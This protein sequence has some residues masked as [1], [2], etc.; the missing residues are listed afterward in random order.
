MLKMDFSLSFPLPRLLVILTIIDG[1][2]CSDIIQVAGDIGSTVSIP[3][4]IQNTSS[5]LVMKQ[6]NC[7]HST[8]VSMD[9]C[10]DCDERMCLRKGLLEIKNLTENDEGKYTLDSENYSQTL[11][12]RLCEL[13]LVVHIHCLSDGRADLFCEA[14]GQSNDSIHW[15]LNGSGMNDI[16]ACQKDGGKRIILEK[17]VHGKLACHRRNSCSSSSI[18]LS[19]NEGNEGSL[20]QPEDLLQ[21]PLFLY[22]LAGCGGGALLLAILASLITCCCLKSK[23]HFISVPAEDEKDEGINLAAISSEGQKSPP[24]GERCEATS[25]LGDST[26]NPGPET[27]E[28]FKPE[29]K[30]DLTTGAK[31][32]S[33]PKI[34]EKAGTETEF[35]EVMVDSAALEAVDVHFPDLTDA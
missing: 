2:T 29:R 7:A 19:C 34:D 3:L 24:N 28:S 25:A 33:E 5:F 20:L 14:G 30:V 8:N 23:H 13:P 12:L 21:N 4:K 35:R 15:T 31:I 16:D 6:M 11:L 17:G 22:I 18:E 10:S 9:C 26:T 1:W 27:G 32:E